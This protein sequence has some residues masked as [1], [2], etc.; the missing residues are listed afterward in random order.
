MKSYQEKK[1]NIK[2]NWY[3]IDAEGLVLGRLSTEVANILRG[4]NKPTYTPNQDCG[5]FVIIINAEKVKLTG[6]KLNK[7]FYY[8]HSGYVGG[9]RERTAKVMKENYPEEMLERAIKG[10]IP[11]TRLGR[12]V[13]KKLFVYRG[14]DHPHMAQQ[15][16]ELKLKGDK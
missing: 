4:K 1:E 7:K 2:R 12:K 8:N 10:M 16:K 15:P 11:H 3:I 9:L 6:D 5:D 13:A 14:S